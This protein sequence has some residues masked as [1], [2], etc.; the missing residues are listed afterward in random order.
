MRIWV[1]GSAGMLGSAFF[2]YLSERNV[3]LLATGRK[4]VDIT[5]KASIEHFVHQHHPHIWINCTAYTQ[6]DLAEDE[7]EKAF[8]V[9]CTGVENLAL[10]AKQEHEK[11][12]SVKLIH[13]STDYV[14]DGK[15]NRPYREDELAEPINVYGKSKLEGE[16]KLA[17]IYP[18]HLIFRLSWL[19][20]INGQNFVKSM[21]NLMQK[22]EVLHIVEDQIG[23]PTFCQDV[24]EAVW[25]LQQETGL[26]HLCNQDPVSW[27]GFAQEIAHQATQ[28]GANLKAQLIEPISAADFAR[29]ASRP[30][31]SVLDTHKIESIGVHLRPWQEALTSCLQALIPQRS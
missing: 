5:D 8:A 28:M 22:Q 1:I 30:A 24:V 23:R 20:G 29:K 4:E 13:F 31:Y 12:H 26:F 19:F 14:F 17:Q 3:T 27:H 6:V 2:R 11:G 18:H 25:D 7:P 10:C 21:L 15:S 16:K 9:N